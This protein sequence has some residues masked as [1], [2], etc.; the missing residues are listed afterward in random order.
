[1]LNDFVREQN[2]K[3][4]IEFGCGD[5]NQLS[6]A[7]Y[8][9]YSGFDVSTE[10]VK[11]CKEMFNS[12]STKKFDLV[13]NYKGESA[14]LALSLDVLYHLI[15]DSV[16]ESYIKRLFESSTKFTIIYSSN[17]NEQIK[18]ISPHVKHRKW[19]DWVAMN[20]KDWKLIRHIPN[21]Y[22]YN[23]DCQIS[24]FSEFYIYEYDA[25]IKQD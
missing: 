25:T 3:T 15:E 20:I 11:I 13:D 12:C 19:S 23:G 24:S 10:A 5:G 18:P 8:P 1:V 21:K 17:T 4:V 16:F 14:E 6:L 9:A 22:P 2:I 7:C